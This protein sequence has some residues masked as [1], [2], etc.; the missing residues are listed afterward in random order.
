MDGARPPAVVKTA[1]AGK[2]VKTAV[3]G[4]NVSELSL[5]KSDVYDANYETGKLCQVQRDYSGAVTKYEAFI[6]SHPSDPRVASALTR[7]FVCS[8]RVA[9]KSAMSSF[10]REQEKTVVPKQAKKTAHYLYLESLAREGSPNEA[11]AG[12]EELI[13]HSQSREDS[14]QAVVTAMGLHLRYGTTTKLATSY[15][16]DAVKTF[17]EFVR[18]AMRLTGQLHRHKSPTHTQAAPVA[19]PT[20]YRLYQNY[21]NPFN[22]NT[23]IHFDLPEAVKV[24]L[25]VFNVL[26]QQVTTLVN[27]VRPAGVYRVM[28][29]GK[30]AGGSSVASGVY[31]YQLKAGS[32][33]D[34]K[35]MVLIR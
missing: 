26:G 14:V 18:R 28:W 6:R 30:S 15:P 12:V 7:H 9:Q 24:Q 11:L 1:I 4:K 5:R 35:K 34:A 23:E 13:R 33:V 2:V 27:D 8:S 25:K 29:D 19:I 22:P 17:P 21:P 32:F 16:E 3:A 31:V 20:A 10:Y